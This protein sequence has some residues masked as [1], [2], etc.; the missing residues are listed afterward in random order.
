MLNGT[1]RMGSGGDTLQT[2]DDSTLTGEF[3]GKLTTTGPRSFGI[4]AVAT[5]G[6]SSDGNA[7]FHSSGS[8]SGDSIEGGRPGH[9]AGG[10][11]EGPAAGG[12]SR[13]CLA[14]GVRDGDYDEVC[15]GGEE[16][17]EA[18]AEEAVAWHSL[19]ATPLV[20]KATG[21][22]VGPLGVSPGWK[23]AEGEWEPAALCLGGGR[24]AQCKMKISL[25]EVWMNRREAEIRGLACM[26]PTE[27]AISQQ[28]TY[29]ISD[30]PYISTLLQMLLLVQTNVSA[31]VDHEVRMTLM[32]EAQMGML[33]QVGSMC[34]SMD[35][36]MLEQ[37]RG[38]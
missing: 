29:F 20:D 8:Q 27:K 3:G 25:E 7:G 12:L 5:P 38:V 11:S 19:E 18:E 16:K 31:R 33:E 34:E 9:G 1:L 23:W 17:R 2:D 22:Q 26:R 36:G 13:L 32:N 35:I 30:C 37:V 24:S 4:S 28:H 21:K 15:D 6:V 14:G 10:G